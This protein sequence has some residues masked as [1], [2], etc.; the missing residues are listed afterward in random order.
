MISRNQSPFGIILIALVSTILMFLVFFLLNYF[1]DGTTWTGMTLSKSALT[2]E[3]C[4]FDN[5]E[6]LFHQNMNTYSNLIYFFLGV[7]IFLFSSSNTERQAP[8][9]RLVDFSLLSKLLGICFI[10]LSFGSAFF[11]ASL[12]WV[13]Q[14]VDMNGT[15]SMSI[16][17]L[18]I[19]FY[20][21]FYKIEL[22]A[23]GKKI[24]I[25]GLVIL[26]VA[27]YEIQ[28]K[29]SSSI[30]LPAFIISIWLLTIINYF[31]F[32]KQRSLLLAILSFALIV[33]AI[34]IRQMD[35]D[36]IGCDPHSPFQGHALWHIMTGMS[37]FCGW[38]F[39]R[40]GKVGKGLP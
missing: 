39:F 18:V 9:N 3:Y 22:S 38:S 29:V 13:G 20:S 5:T 33:V 32:R 1:L 24:M 7:L 16:V 17:T 26:I 2:G 31:Q 34:K 37:S 19:A 12:T 27:F 15:Y 23:S 10:Y 40:F 25:A 30:L 6:A 36:K 28:L 14:R 8:Y 11:H 35:V 4:E 21:V